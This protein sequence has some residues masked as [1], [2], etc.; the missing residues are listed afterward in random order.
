MNKTILTIALL[1]AL[2]VAC[3]GGNGLN[4]DIFI[5]DHLTDRLRRENAEHYAFGCVDV[6][7]TVL[8]NNLSPNAIAI[9]ADIER[10]H[11]ANVWLSGPSAAILG[12]NGQRSIVIYDPASEA[13]NAQEFE[14]RKV[15]TGDGTLIC[16][17]PK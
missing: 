9:D 1:M 15:A 2:L 17:V 11:T 12:G 6:D 3:G 10:E 4:D 14:Q 7:G 13:T 8:S 16:F 5:V